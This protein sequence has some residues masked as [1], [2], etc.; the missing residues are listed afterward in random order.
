MGREHVGPRVVDQTFGSSC[1]FHFYPFLWLPHA[2]KAEGR[3]VELG[4]D[5]ASQNHAVGPNSVG[6]TAAEDGYKQVEVG[7]SFG[8]EGYMQVEAGSN[9]VEGV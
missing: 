7:N 2:H 5:C 6:Q 1:P 4:K 8:G 3:L 9:F